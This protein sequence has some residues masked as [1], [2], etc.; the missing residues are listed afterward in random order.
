MQVCILYFSISIINKFYIN[1]KYNYRG[2][3]EE[4]ILSNALLS[5]VYWLINIYENS[6]D[7][8]RKNEYLQNGMVLCYL[9]L[10]QIIKIFVIIKI[11][12]N[13]YV[14]RTRND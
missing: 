12:F 14:Y 9:K 5:L 1:I 2:K 13:K 11:K 3:A 7:A 6:L 8:F 10:S 4:S